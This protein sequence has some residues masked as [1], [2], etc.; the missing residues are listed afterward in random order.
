MVVVAEHTENSQRSP[1]R[2]DFAKAGFHPL[3]PAVNVVPGE[4]R[5][6]RHLRIRETNGRTDVLARNPFSVVEVREKGDFQSVE[7]RREIGKMDC[8]AMEADNS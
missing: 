2:G 6:V 3:C 8:P 7:S 5:D 4:C 1:E